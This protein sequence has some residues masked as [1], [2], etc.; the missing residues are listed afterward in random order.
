MSSL[1]GRCSDAGPTT[2]SDCPTCH[3]RHWA[4]L[5]YCHRCND[6][7]CSECAIDTDKGLMC[8]KCLTHMVANE[9]EEDWPQLASQADVLEVVRLCNAADDGPE[10]PMLRQ[11]DAQVRFANIPEWLKPVKGWVN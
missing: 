3:S 11:I 9:P 1:P 10:I 5:S 4:T 6:T 2:R 7:A 8:A